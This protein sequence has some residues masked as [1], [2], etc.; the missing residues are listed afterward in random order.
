MNILITGGA[1]YIGSHV[2]VALIEAGHSVVI[3]DNYVNSLPDAA[4]RIAK[5]TGQSAP[6]YKVDVANSQELRAVFAEGRIDGVVHCAGFKAAGESAL[7]PLKYY[8]NNIDCSL[9][10]LEVMAEYQVKLIVFS[11][12]ALVYGTPTVVASKVLPF[13]E[14]MPPGD[15][16]NPYGTTKFFIERIIADGAAADPGLAAV[17]LRYFNPAGAHKSALIGELPRGIPNNLMPYITQVA[18]GKLKEL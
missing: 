7:N 6:A 13:V 12:S 9:T 1:G 16:A 8:R 5:I 3:A 15:C 10:L 11:S 14:D 4:A 17:N 18:A 2:A